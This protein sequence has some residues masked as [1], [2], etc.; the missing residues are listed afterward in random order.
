MFLDE[1][2]INIDM[3]RLYT[4][5]SRGQRVYDVPDTRWKAMSMISSLRL[6][7]QTES[8]VYKDSLTGDF[9]KQWLKEALC[10]IL[11]A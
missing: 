9:L 11:N 2:S 1:S 8:L 6:N 4:R 3:T 7:G 10:P 5:G